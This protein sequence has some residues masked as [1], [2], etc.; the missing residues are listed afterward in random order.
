MS[1]RKS[2]DLPSRKGMGFQRLNGNGCCFQQRLRYS[3]ADRSQI[4]SICC[5]YNVLRIMSGMGGLALLDRA[6]QLL[7]TV[8]SKIINYLATFSN[9][10]DLLRHSP[11]N[12]TVNLDNPQP[13]LT[14]VKTVQRLNGNGCCHKQRLRYSPSPREHSKVPRLQLDCRYGHHTGIFLASHSTCYFYRK[15][16]KIF[17]DTSF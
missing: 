5:N 9:C 17:V 15:I 1:M 3:P 13:T 11:T 2:A 14:L 12:S 16:L 10:G 4:Q 7:K 8:V 6:K